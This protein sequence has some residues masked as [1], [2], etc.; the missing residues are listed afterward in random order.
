[1]WAGLNNRVGAE[2]GTVE[3]QTRVGL[4]GWG[5]VRELGSPASI[6]KK[7]YSRRAGKIVAGILRTTLK[8]IGD[9]PFKLKMAV[10]STK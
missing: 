9:T 3:L 7:A 6:E 8:T 4:P 10:T 2:K 5:L 1:M